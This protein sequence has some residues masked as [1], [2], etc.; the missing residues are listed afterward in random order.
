MALGDG[1]QRRKYDARRHQKDDR[2]E[3]DTNAE[4]ADDASKDSSS[5]KRREIEAA[6]VHLA[7]SERASRDQP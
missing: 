2:R 5:R 6:L 3:Q 4:Q 7:H 1:P